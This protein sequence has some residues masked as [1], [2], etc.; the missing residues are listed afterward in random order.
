MCLASP[1][2][3]KGRAPM[4]VLETRRFGYLLLPA[5]QAVNFQ[6]HVLLDHQNPWATY[7]SEF[8]AMK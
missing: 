4:R 6:L 2:G 5:P 8:S 1:K 7:C 3:S